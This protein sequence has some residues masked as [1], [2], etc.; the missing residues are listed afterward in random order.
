VR[1]TRLQCRCHGLSGSCSARTCFRRAPSLGDVGGRLRAR[2]DGAVQVTVSN[3]DGR[4]LQ[5]LAAD[6]SPLPLGDELLAFA[7]ESPDYC[8]R[9]RRVGSHGT[10]R[11]FCSS[12]SAGPEGCAVLCCGRGYR[13]RTLTV[14]ENCRCTFR[15]C[16]HVACQTCVANKTVHVCR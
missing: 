6:H 1:Y 8:R 2:Y 14:T 5:P 7:T 10:R 15:W 3:A 13:T 4:T 12:R 9:S 16:C 11:R